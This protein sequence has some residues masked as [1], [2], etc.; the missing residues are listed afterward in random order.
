MRI[1]LGLETQPEV[2]FHKP[3]LGHKSSIEVGLVDE[4]DAYGIPFQRPMNG[5]AAHLHAPTLTITQA[6]KILRKKGIL[7]GNNRVLE[8]RLAPQTEADD[9][10]GHFV[11]IGIPSIT[12]EEKR[13]TRART[14]EIKQ[15]FWSP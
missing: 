6:E 13:L 14:R 10:I 2:F 15:H 8:L 7:K 12:E 3:N 11:R 1:K 5:A 9:S 4:D